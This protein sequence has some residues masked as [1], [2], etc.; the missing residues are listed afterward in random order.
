MLRIDPHERPTAIVAA[1]D[2]IALGALLTCREA[3]V[4][5]PEE[6][7]VVGFDDIPFAAL[8]FPPL[9][10]VRQPIAKLGVL[11]ARPKVH[12]VSPDLVARG[13]TEPVATGTAEALGAAIANAS[14]V[15]GLTLEVGR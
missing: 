5:I 6:L 4:A 2:L 11:A 1:N 13:S 14:E 12:T 10:T 15:A 7:S 3:G 9:T 8:A